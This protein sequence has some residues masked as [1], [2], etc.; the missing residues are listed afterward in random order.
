MCVLL[1][2]CRRNAPI[3]VDLEQKITACLETRFDKSMK[4]VRR[5]FSVDCVEQW[6]KVWRLDGDMMH[7]STWVTESEDRRDA[8]FVRVSTDDNIHLFVLAAD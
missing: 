4:V 7:A 5:Y 8:T 3:D 2:P 1:P 6:G